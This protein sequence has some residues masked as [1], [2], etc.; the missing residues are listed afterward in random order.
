MLITTMHNRHLE[1]NFW[2][3]LGLKRISSINSCNLRAYS[4]I[5]GL[6]TNAFKNIKLWVY[7]RE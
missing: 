6:S 7:N 4:E 1:F 3:G 2:R 5:T